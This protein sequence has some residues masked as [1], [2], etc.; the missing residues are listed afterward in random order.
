ML[1]AVLTI[2]V[3]G[4][5]T[6]DDGL[7][8]RVASAFLLRTVDPGLHAIAHD[9]VAE[10]ADCQCLEHDRA[11]AG[12]AEVLA[13]NTGMPDPVGS[14]VQQWIGSAP[15]HAILADGTYGLIGCAEAVTGGTH[16]FACVLLPGPLPPQPPPPAPVTPSVAPVPVPVVVEAP[17]EEPLV[18]QTTG[19]VDACRAR[20]VLM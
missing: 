10:L 13:M 11:R 1:A 2:V 17:P 14:A 16:W 12:T 4:V 5:A 8:G 18:A 6:A 7:T 20:F 19:F 15:H 3:G 9:R